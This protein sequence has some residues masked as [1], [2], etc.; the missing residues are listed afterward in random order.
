MATMRDAL[1]A[2]LNADATLTALLPGGFV[3]ANSLPSEWSISD[4]P[5]DGAMITPFAVLRWRGA[6]PTEIDLSERRTVEIYIYQHK[7][8]DI[9]EQAKRR[10]KTILNRTKVSSDDAGI[11]MYH[12]LPDLHDFSAEEIGGAAASGCKFYTDYIMK[13]N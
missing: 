10:I 6:V 3:D 8:Y 11:C 4:V 9:I 1:R 12:K 5:R 2:F 7:G 13:E